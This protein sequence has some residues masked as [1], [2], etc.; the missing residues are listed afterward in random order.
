MAQVECSLH[1]V[2]RV[3]R[4]ELE[5]LLWPRSVPLEVTVKQAAMYLGVA[6]CT[7][8]KWVVSGELEVGRR[9]GGRF[10]IRLP[11]STYSATLGESVMQH[12]SRHRALRY[13][14]LAPDPQETAQAQAERN[15]Q[16]LAEVTDGLSDRVGPGEELPPLPDLKSF[17]TGRRRGLRGVAG[18]WATYSAADWEQIP[19]Q[20]GLYALYLD[21][22]LMYIGRHENVRARLTFQRNE[23]VFGRLP[24]MR[25]KDQAK[26]VVIK[27]SPSRRSG[28]ELMR[29]HRLLKRLKPPLNE[30][31]R[32]RRGWL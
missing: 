4:E 12:F 20:A 25:P 26:R 7:I 11:L 6:Q 5:K 2:R 10:W 30:P 31:R 23:P 13:L 24:R 1:D 14:L 19:E 18:R 16:F 28:E 27:F 9:I 21:G 29:A 32:S 22:K 8:R 17:Q 15:E 3:V